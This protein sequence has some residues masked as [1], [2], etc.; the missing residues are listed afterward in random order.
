[1]KVGWRV[2][3]SRVVGRSFCG[4]CFLVSGFEREHAVFA[5]GL[6]FSAASCV[7]V[8]LLLGFIFILGQFKYAGG[9]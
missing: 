7:G 5:I 6:S 3:F 2:P 9:V 8:G 1:M 4:G